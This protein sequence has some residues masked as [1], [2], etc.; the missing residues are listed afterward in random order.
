MERIDNVISLPKAQPVRIKT[1]ADIGT[2]VPREKAY[3]RPLDGY[4]GL[5][6]RVSPNGSKRFLTQL[7]GPDKRDKTISH[8]E[9]PNLSLEQAVMLHK[10]AYQLIRSGDSPRAQKQAKQRHAERNHMLSRPIVE[11]GHER[12]DRAEAQG[13]LTPQTAELDRSVLNKYLAP[14]LG[15][16]SFRDFSEGHL[17]MLKDT[18][19]AEQGWTKLDKATKMLVKVY[20]SLDTDIQLALNSDIPKQIQRTIGPIKQ[21]TRDEHRIEPQDLAKFW[22]ALLSAPHSQKLKDAYLF[23]L[24]SGERRTACLRAEKD[25]VRHDP[26]LMIHLVTKGTRDGKGANI[27]PA[28]GP[29]GLLLSR[30]LKQADSNALF[31]ATR[32]D[33]AHLS[34]ASLKALVR[35]L[36]KDVPHCSPHDLRRTLAHIAW[37]ATGSVE[38]AN[39]HLLHSRHFNKGSS[40]HYFDERAIEF[41]RLRQDTFKKT[42][43]SLDNLILKH[44]EVEFEGFMND[45]PEVHNR[46]PIPARL[47]V[48]TH[49][50]QVVIAIIR[51]CQGLTHYSSWA[52]FMAYAEVSLPIASMCRDGSVD[53]IYRPIRERRGALQAI[54]CQIDMTWD[55]PKDSTETTFLSEL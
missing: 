38:I 30:L 52:D 39:E 28:A 3:S 32:G 20:N 5:R 12:T 17:K 21:R 40:K 46:T 29:M 11:L 49:R 44:C 15:Q 10:T 13:R 16:T 36:S 42:Y 8:G 34:D 33:N 25:K 53:S 48:N 19:P 55:T 1:D 31:P 37:L 35:T 2:L 7:Q 45:D 47:V 6:L 50:E 24:L 14:V 18:Y 54:K 4:T 22:G 26:F 27:L 51:H 9:W 41:A 43:Q 23:I